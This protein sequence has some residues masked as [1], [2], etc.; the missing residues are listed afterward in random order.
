VDYSVI[1]GVD[2]LMVHITEKY[3]SCKPAVLLE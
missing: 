1:T 2:I 3:D